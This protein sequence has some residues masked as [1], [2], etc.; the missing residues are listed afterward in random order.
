MEILNV[1][2]AAVGAFAFGAAWYMSL[3]KQWMAATGITDAQQQGTMDHKQLCLRGTPSIIDVDQWRLCR[4][5]EYYHWIY[6]N[7]IL[8]N[9]RCSAPA[10]TATSKHSSGAFQGLNLILIKGTFVPITKVPY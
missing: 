9:G 8:I 5:R 7:I 1:L 10:D 2:A 3:A 6:F 4:R